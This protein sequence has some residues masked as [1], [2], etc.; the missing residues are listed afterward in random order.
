MIDMLMMTPMFACP[1][2]DRVLESPRPEDEGKKLDRPAGAEGD[3]GIEAMI[4]ER[5]TE[6][7]GE[8]HHE[9]EPQLKPIQTEMVEV[10]RNSGQRQNERPNQKGTGNPVDPIE[11]QAQD[12]PPWPDARRR[13]RLNVAWSVF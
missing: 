1:H 3:M 9:E 2:Q 8:K 11:G 6:S 10:E 7:A 5:D 12:R 4:S 13:S